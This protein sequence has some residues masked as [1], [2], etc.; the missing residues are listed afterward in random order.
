[1]S[2]NLIMRSGASWTLNP[3]PTTDMKGRRDESYLPPTCLRT[4]LSGD[5]M[6][7]SKRLRFEIL[8]RDQHCCRYCGEHASPQVKLT[9]D[10]VLPV[11]LGGNDDPTN[12]AAACQPCNAGKS[13]SSPDAPLVAQVSDDEIRWRRAMASAAKKRLRRVKDMHKYMG[14]FLDIWDQ[15]DTDFRHLPGDWKIMLRYWWSI[16]LPLD[17]VHDALSVA[18]ERYVRRDIPAKTVYPYMIGVVKNML[19]EMQQDAAASMMKG[20]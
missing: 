14:Q 13:A 3:C 5:L 9:V 6:A 15:W 7:I 10:H 19:T 11:A 2:T 4:R 16:E 12:L 20:R 17:L 8:R 1:M 18:A